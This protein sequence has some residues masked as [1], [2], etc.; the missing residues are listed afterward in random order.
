[1]SFPWDQQ[2]C[3]A[4]ITVSQLTLR[5]NQKLAAS[6]EIIVIMHFEF[7]YL[8]ANQQLT[9]FAMPLCV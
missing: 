3:A 4:Y 7:E 5:L 1:M 2:I 9:I 6:I 8:S